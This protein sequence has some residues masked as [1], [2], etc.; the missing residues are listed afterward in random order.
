MTFNKW[1]RFSLPVLFILLAGRPFVAQATDEPFY[2][3]FFARVLIY[4]LAACALN[5]VLG[6]AGLVSF[7]HAMF[8]GVGCYAVAIR[9]GARC[10]SVCA[11]RFA[12]VCVYPLL[13]RAWRLCCSRRC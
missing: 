7:G 8:I 6:F 12:Q 3:T 1:T 9:H 13:Q 10:P 11:H 5:I 2:V 4:D